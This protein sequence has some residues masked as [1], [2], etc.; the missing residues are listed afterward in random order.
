MFHTQKVV[1][2]DTIRVAVFYGPQLLCTT[3]ATIDASGDIDLRWYD[4]DNLE[5]ARMIDFA[6]DFVA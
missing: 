4:Y 5:H 2:E 6:E 3:T 1:E